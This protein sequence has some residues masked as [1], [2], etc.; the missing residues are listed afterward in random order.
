MNLNPNVDQTLNMNT[1][2]INKSQ[3][4]TGSILVPVPRLKVVPEIS[5]V[6]NTQK[7]FIRP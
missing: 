2:G 7:T 1:K 4:N 5:F 6:S 3:P